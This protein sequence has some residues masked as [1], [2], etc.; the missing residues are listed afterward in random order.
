MNFSVGCDFHGVLD[1]YPEFFSWLT[2][3]LYAYGC[4]IHI[5]TGNKITQEFL[6]QL[7]GY[8]I[9]Y[10]HI[11]SI[12]D[13]HEQIGTEVLYDERGPWIDADTWNRTKA[14]YCESYSITV[15][16]DDSDVYG[17]YFTSTLYLQ[18]TNGK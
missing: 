5:I 3:I 6:Q 14:E 7:N 11:F 18:L 12:V 9:S 16:I 8:G 1:R 17:Q 15:H 13:Y 10:T 2:K 4:E